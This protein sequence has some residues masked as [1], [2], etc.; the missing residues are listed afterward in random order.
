MRWS[1]VL[2]L[3]LVAFATTILGYGNSHADAVTQPY[4]LPATDVVSSPQTLATA[5][6]QSYWTL[7]RMKAA[8]PVLMQFGRRSTSPQPQ[9]PVIQSTPSEES[10]PPMRP[11][12]KK[13]NLPIARPGHRIAPQVTTVAHPYAYPYSTVG[14]VFFTDPQTNIDYVCS[15]TVVVS[16]NHSTVDTAGHCV[17]DGGN[18]YFYT[19][20]A[21]CAGYYNGCPSG[22]LW[23]ARQ[24]LTHTHWYYDGWLTY[25]YGEAVLNPNSKGRVADVVGSAGWVY[26]QPYQQQFTALGYPQAYPFNGTRLWK[27]TSSLYRS[28]QPN[29]GPATMSIAC[30]MTGGSS[31]GG[32]LISHNGS[33]GYLNGHN[34][35]KYA[36]DS[37]HMYSPYYGSDWYNV[38][39]QAQQS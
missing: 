38:Y 12:N 30:D 28:D 9:P 24:L 13:M 2:L 34:D 1:L 27:C 16:N 8:H 29:P 39:D 20:W 22:Y 5:R 33:F 37:Q 15:G 17:A 11:A 7:A 6:V 32:W 23:S 36:N 18:Q 25:D 21:F 14:K 26:N 3:C 4:P 19:N 31:G 35:Y 10:Q